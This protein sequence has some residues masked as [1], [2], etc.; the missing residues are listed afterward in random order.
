M[1][2]Q[3]DPKKRGKRKRGKKIRRKE[4]IEDDCGYLEE[5]EAREEDREIRK[6]EE[7]DEEKG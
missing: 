6:A 2:R 1:K 5:G 3:N 4:E 7:G